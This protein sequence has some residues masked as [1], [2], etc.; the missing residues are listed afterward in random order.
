M[1]QY[2]RA[3]RMWKYAAFAGAALA[4][5]CPSLPPQYRVVCDLLSSVCSM[6]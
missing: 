6:R 4:I 1:S 5:L 2:D 3:R